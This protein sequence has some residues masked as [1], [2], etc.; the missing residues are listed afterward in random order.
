M[1]SVTVRK[2]SNAFA[3]RADCACRVAP[4][5]V[6]YDSAQAQWSGPDGGGNIYYNGGKVGIGTSSP[7]ANL[8]IGNGPAMYGA[9]GSERD[10]EHAT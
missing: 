6:R 7:D 3:N 2:S 1:K 8:H 10:S 9:L 4:D 5:S